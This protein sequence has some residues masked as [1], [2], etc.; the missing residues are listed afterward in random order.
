[1][2]QIVDGVDELA[3]QV[4][5]VQFVPSESS[6]APATKNSEATA[7]AIVDRNFRAPQWREATRALARPVMERTYLLGVVAESARL[8]RTLPA[9]V[10]A[11]AK[12]LRMVGPPHFLGVKQSSAERFLAAN[13]IELPDGV[14]VTLPPWLRERMA[15][16]IDLLMLEDFW[17]ALTTRTRSDIAAVLKRGLED[18]E[19]INRISR[20]IQRAAP[21]YGR[22]RA[23][24]LAR[25]EVN[26]VL[27]EAKMGVMEQV[28]EETGGA[29]ATRKWATVGDQR[30][31]PRTAPR[32][33]RNGASASHSTSPDSRQC[34]LAIQHCLRRFGSIAGAR[35]FPTW[36]STRK[37]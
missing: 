4:S 25:T 23:D 16:A 27:N 30:V 2:A 10:I 32:T 26:G 8:S 1:M 33:A 35:R 9:D 19:P 7:L 22:V 31:R 28:A 21:Q 34:T 29:I 14:T 6:T 15:R 20:S 11:A 18:G 3:E 37:F 17:D 36:A 24:R 12:S 13:G 5:G